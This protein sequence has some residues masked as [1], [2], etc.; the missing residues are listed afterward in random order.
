MLSWSSALPHSPDVC[1]SSAKGYKIA[2][3]DSSLIAEVGSLT[4]EFTRLCQLTNDPRYFDAVQRIT[5]V[6]DQAQNQTRIPGLWP[7]VCNANSLN[8]EYNHFTLGGM[9]DSTYEYLPKEYIMLGGHSEQ[10]QRMYET[11]MNVA[12]KHIF[13]RPM[14]KDNQDILFSGNVRLT[15]AK[16]VSLDPQ[17]QHLACFTGGMVG[18]GAK[19]FNHPE[20]LAIARKL[21]DGCIWAYESMPTGLMPETFHMLPCDDPEYCPWDS[22]KWRDGI[23]QH[24]SQTTE[25]GTMKPDERAEHWIKVKKLVPGYTDIGDARYILRYVSNIPLPPS[26]PSYPTILT[27]PSLRSRAA[28]SGTSVSTTHLLSATQTAWS[29]FGWRRR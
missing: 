2:A 27:P 16:E 21:V 24:Q 15:T 4:V 20:D 14:T 25:T 11:A 7:V 10:Y 22:Q 29:P 3:T 26:L 23:N 13:F 18:V 12:K 17:G 28:V 19:I 9:T 1:Y 6:L 5:D 8:F